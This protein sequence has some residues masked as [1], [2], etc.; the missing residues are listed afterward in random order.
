MKL[1]VLQHQQQDPGQGGKG[2]HVERRRHVGDRAEVAVPEARDQYD[3][4]EGHEVVGMAIRHA[5]LPGILLSLFF[6]RVGA[7]S[8]DRPAPA[9]HVAARA[10][11][12][13]RQLDDVVHDQVEDAVEVELGIERPGDALDALEA[14]AR[15][16]R[17]AAGRPE[18][19]IVDA[20]AVGGHPEWPGGGIHYGE[21]FPGFGLAGVGVVATVVVT[22]TLFQ[23]LKRN[24]P[25]GYYQQRFVIWLHDKGLR[26]SAL[27][28]RSGSWDIGRTSALPK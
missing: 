17:H 18:H 9:W 23:R 27:V 1:R 14:V 20:V 21:Q 25:D 15:A 26:R 16:A 6:I 2:M 3:E 5:V 28:R 19:L 7:A 12:G 24:R 11:L 13:L 10:A 22:A 8:S 4:Y